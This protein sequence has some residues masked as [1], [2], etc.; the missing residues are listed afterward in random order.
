M[1]IIY[2]S[3]SRIPTEKAHGLQIMKMCE[4]F[5][6]HAH[7]KL[8]LPTRRNNSEFKNLDPFKYYSTSSKFSIK[9][10]L[11]PDPWLLY[12]YKI[13]SGL[14]IKIQAS[15]F[16]LS[17]F[18]YFIFN[19]SQKSI[20]YTRDEHLLPI[21]QIFS[22]KV[23]WEAHTLPNNYQPYLRY[24]KKCPKI[25]C[26]SQSLKNSLIKW[27]IDKNKILVA[28]DGVDLD[29]FSISE[30]KL[31]IRQKLNL[32]TD[33]KIII[34][35]GHLYAWKGV[36]TLANS[37]KF[38]DSETLIIFI[39]G[40]SIDIKKFKEK[41]KKQP[42]I[43]IL[44][45]QVPQKIPYYLKAADVLI[46]PNTSLN[47]KSFWTSPL[48]LFEYMATNKPIVASN[49]PN[50]REILNKNNG[51]FFKPNDSQDLAQKIKYILNNP[52]PAQTLAN[53]AR[54]DVQKYIWPKRAEK[55]IKFIN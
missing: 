53:Q 20:L 29:K 49:L 43:K 51:I 18:F 10:I 27:G 4:V 15:F 37:A 31:E 11:T 1:Q 45:Y 55:I 52:Q 26:I 6:N 50:I 22:K 25:I 30:S 42:N 32:P 44:G 48:K 3:N 23:I 24:W 19:K 7:V 21:L 38:L 2:V 12:K 9:K 16:I 35:A 28:H 13:S 5:S 33:K 39:G 36:Q 41:N 40:T 47:K 54:Q 17:L 14:Y 46:L 8:L 34:Y